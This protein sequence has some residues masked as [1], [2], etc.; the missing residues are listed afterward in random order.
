MHVRIQMLPLR[1]FWQSLCP[2]RIERQLCCSVFANYF[3]I[4]DYLTKIMAFRLFVAR[5]ADFFWGNIT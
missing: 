5:S 3:S 2:L 4:P 1:L